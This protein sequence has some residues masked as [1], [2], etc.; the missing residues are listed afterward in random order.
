MLSG[1]AG[2][3]LVML[4]DFAEGHVE[5]AADVLE[6][7]LGAERA[8][9]DDLRDLLA[10]VFLGDVL[11]HFAAAIGAEVDVD[12]GH[13][14]AFRIEE[15]LEEQAVVQRVDVGDPHRVADQA[16]GGRTAAGTDRD[17]LRFGVADEVPND[18][19]VAG[20]LHLLDQL[21]FAVEPFDVFGHVVPQMARRAGGASRRSAP[22]FEALAGHVFEVRVDGVLGR[23]VELAG[24]AP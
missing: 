19:E 6:R 12:V 2:T 24:R 8:E 21:D 20:E 16:S 5:R 10:A 9:G 11:D 15:A 22:L 1:C 18:Q 23:D 14:D 3:S 4:V 7:R 13:A 17:A